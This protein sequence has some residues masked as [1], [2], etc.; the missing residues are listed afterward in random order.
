MG[1]QSPR[2]PADGQQVSAQVR[3]V[4]T[5]VRASFSDHVANHRRR[6]DHP[7]WL[8]KF[9]GSRYASTLHFCSIHCRIYVFR[10]AQDSQDIKTRTA[11]GWARSRRCR[12]ITGTCAPCAGYSYGWECYCR[13]RSGYW[14]RTA[15]HRIVA[16]TMP[17]CR[18]DRGHHQTL[19]R[20]FGHLEF[21]R[22]SFPFTF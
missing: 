5:P 19:K 18:R 17:S 14:N 4:R 6:A 8:M 9:S 22:P 15:R 1:T 20:S 21:G 7:P 13:T 10:L 3:T 11:H 2:L 12:S 16:P